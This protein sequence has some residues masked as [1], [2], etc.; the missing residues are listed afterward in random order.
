MPGDVGLFFYF[1]IKTNAKHGA[2][3]L[4]S[5]ATN[6][7]REKEKYLKIEKSD[8]VLTRKSCVLRVKTVF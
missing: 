4:M 1:V 8:F 3:A 6:D 7:T 5:L 2:A